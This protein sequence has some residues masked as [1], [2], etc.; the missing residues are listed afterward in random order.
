MKVFELESKCMEA[1]V[2]IISLTVSSLSAVA[3]SPKVY[4]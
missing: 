4:E 2:T 3:I 1:H